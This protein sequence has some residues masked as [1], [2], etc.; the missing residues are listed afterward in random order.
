MGFVGKVKSGNVMSSL[1][2]IDKLSER[3]V[4]RLLSLR[5]VHLHGN[6]K[7]S[8]SGLDQLT[9]PSGG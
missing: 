2:R 1:G 5:R 8:R 7:I 3:S 9:F 4:P 6:S